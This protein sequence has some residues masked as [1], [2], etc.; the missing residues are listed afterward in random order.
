VER[1]EE[2]DRMDLVGLYMPG[3][4]LSRT[5]S[6]LVMVGLRTPLSGDL[7]TRV[8]FNGTIFAELSD[9]WVLALESDY[10]VDTRLS[11]GWTII[12]QVHVNAGRHFKLQAGVGLAA[13]DEEEMTEG[14]LRAIYEF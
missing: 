6:G 5:W 10:R 8:I 2:D 11:E 9:V 3:Y 12:P 7:E 14:L 1:D 13:E 4:R